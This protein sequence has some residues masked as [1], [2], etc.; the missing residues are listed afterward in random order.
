[1]DILFTIHLWLNASVLECAIE[2]NSGVVGVV[3]SELAT[4]LVGPGVVISSTVTR[5]VGRMTDVDAGVVRTSVL[6]EDSEVGR[7]N[8]RDVDAGVVRS[9]TGAG[10]V[11]LVA[12]AGAGVVV[13]VANAGAGVVVMVADVG[14]GVVMLSDATAG[15]VLE[16]F[17]LLVT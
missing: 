8:G 17:A 1:V 9:D 4:E 14:T 6:N 7:V 15:L 11:M 10:V 5:V 16:T 2:N 3:G 12:N 13:M